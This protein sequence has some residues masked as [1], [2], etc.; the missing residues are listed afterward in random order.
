M[1]KS[2]TPYVDYAH[3]D[4]DLAVVAAP[5]LE[6]IQLIEK[7]I[8]VLNRQLRTKLNAFDLTRRA[9][10]YR[11]LGFIKKALED[12]NVALEMEANFVD[13]Y[14]QRHLVY[15]VQD[16]KIEALEDLNTILKFNRTH[17]GAYLSRCIYGLILF[18]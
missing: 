4:L 12:L 11:K 17:T 13:A 16:R 10:L 15:L 2:P 5:D 7:E 18:V 6:M 8:E 3:I 9:T 14:W 1:A